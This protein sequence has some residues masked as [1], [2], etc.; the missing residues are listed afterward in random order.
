M[1]EREREIKGLGKSQRIQIYGFV[2]D[3]VI[4]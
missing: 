3:G 1:E 4:A 2:I